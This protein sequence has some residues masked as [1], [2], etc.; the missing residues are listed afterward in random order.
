[1]VDGRFTKL[2][3]GTLKSFEE[4]LCA[5]SDSSSEEEAGLLRRRKSKAGHPAMRP[6]S[7]QGGQDRLP[8]L[9]PTT[10]TLDAR[11]SNAA[12]APSSSTAVAAEH[13]GPLEQQPERNGTPSTW[14][15]GV[16][17]DVTLPPLSHGDNPR[18]L[19]SRPT[20][21]RGWSWLAASRAAASAS[22]LQWPDV[23]PAGRQA[24][25]EAAARL[26]AASKAE[27]NANWARGEY[28]KCAEQLSVSIGVNSR[29]DVLR[30]YR[31]KAASRQGDDDAAVRDAQRAVA[32]NAS[33]GRN[34]AA[35]AS[36]ST[37]RTTQTPPLPLPC[38]EH[39]GARRHG[40]AMH[41]L[42]ALR[43]GVVGSQSLPDLGVGGLL[44]AVRRER[45]YAQL[46]R[47]Q[48]G[49]AHSL[50]LGGTKYRADIF[51]P[52]KVLDLSSDVVGTACAPDPPP[53]W[54]AEAAPRQLRLAWDEPEELGS[55]E[56]YRY[57]LEMSE[58]ET[59]Y[60]PHAAGGRPGF[61]EGFRAWAAV[62]AGPARVREC[63]L[64]ALEPDKAYKL[65][66][67]ALNESGESPWGTV[68]EVRT[69]PLPKAG[70]RGHGA[71]VPRSWLQADLA[72]LLAAQ[73]E[74]S[75][76]AAS[77]QQ[78]PAPD[79]GAGPEPEGFEPVALMQQL[80][81]CLAPHVEELHRIFKLYASAG[82]TTTKG[83]R[84]ISSRQACAAFCMCSAVHAR[85]K[86]DSVRHTRLCAS[87][88]LK[89]CKDVGLCMVGGDTTAASDLLSPLSL[90]E[91]R[92][93]PYYP[94][95]PAKAHCART[96]LH[97]CASG[98]A[99]LP[100]GHRARPRVAVPQLAGCAGDRH[101]TPGVYRPG[102][103]RARRGT[104]IIGAVR[105]RRRRNRRRRRRRR[106]R[107]QRRGRREQRGQRGERGRQG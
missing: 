33:G 73:L 49:K 61:R 103:H 101:E 65:R 104:A 2:P 75:A 62:H 44:D 58:F 99:S 37:S 36:A 105:S 22:G 57:E 52:R 47:P 9:V 87:Q 16:P 106:R 83:G 82:T 38:L 17:P 56:I 107:R 32:L 3:G 19:P 23:E 78:G 88:F 81:T 21:H 64:A 6:F 26:C 13:P 15:G 4:F 98:L 85:T 48:H 70:P 74:R 96:S 95:Y 42:E 8:P 89:F 100:A 39:N 27:A 20:K 40:A 46:K 67:R 24:A 55:G 31:A 10:T 60:E 91:V 71:G 76:E 54:L 51:D 102:H 50:L 29:C 79:I 28:A 25:K 66:A 59:V 72:D 69:P 1:M 90:G 11:P 30:R 80:S 93:A 41:R 18:T 35:L 86:N 63:T 53:L 97:V 94:H 77:E 14:E 12:E 45:F 84:E 5:A 43:L 34:H 7:Q 92:T 68:L